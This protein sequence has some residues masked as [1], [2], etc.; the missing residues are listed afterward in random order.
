M[1][2]LKYVLDIEAS[3]SSSGITINQRKYALDI[4]IETDMLDCRPIDTS[5]DLNV[6]L[7]TGQEEPLKDPKRYRRLVG[8]LN[9][10]TVI[11][12]YITFAM[13]IVSQFLNT[14]CDNHQ[15][16]VIRILRYIKSAPGR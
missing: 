6:K 12:P 9:Y 13:S 8:G 2:P 4:L 7:L 14:H 15:D 16:A 11:I 10:L 5:M 3:Q 1:S